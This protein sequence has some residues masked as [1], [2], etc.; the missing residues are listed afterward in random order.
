MAFLIGIYGFWNLWA[1]THGFFFPYIMSTVGEQTQA[2]SVSLQAA[3]FTLAMLSIY[4]IFMKRV[5][6]ANQRVLFGIS[7]AMQIAGM[8]LLLI[9]LGVFVE[10]VSMMMITLPIFMP[11]VQSLGVDLVWFG[12]LFLICMQLG[13]LMPPHGLLLITMKG[14]APPQVTML[15]IFRA[16]AR[17]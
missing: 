4:F 3:N 8:M 2:V 15:H 5:D 13:L 10:Q 1:G 14:V 17:G 6:R 11:V 7:A 9:F 12:V 16:V